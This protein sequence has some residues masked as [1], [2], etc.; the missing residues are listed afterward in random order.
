MALDSA[1]LGAGVALNDLR[2]AA[3]GRGAKRVG[4]DLRV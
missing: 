2:G 3:E 4:G 1:R